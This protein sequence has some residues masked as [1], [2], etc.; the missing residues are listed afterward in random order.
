VALVGLVASALTVTALERQQDRSLDQRLN[1]R[2]KLVQRAVLAETRRYEDALR[3]LAAAI[4]AQSRLTRADFDGITSA[5]TRERLLGVSGVSLVVSA[6]RGEVA[7][8]Q[9]FWRARGST[10]L[11][12]RPVGTGAVEHRFVV[13][14]RSLDPD[15][16][17]VGRDVSESPEAVEAMDRAR[18]TGLPTASRTYVLLKDRNLPPHRRQLSF[19]I[20]VPV[21]LK[22]P[23]QPIHGWLLLGLRGRDLLAATL[24][25]VTQGLVEVALHDPA[26]EGEQPVA[27]WPV[28]DVPERA[29]LPSRTVGV[30]VGQRTWR[31]TVYATDRLVAAERGHVPLTAGLAGIAISGLLALLVLV[32]SRSRDRALVAVRRATTALQADLARR[33]AVEREL[34]QRQAELRAFAGVTAHD[35]RAPLASASVRLE[36]VAEE[37]DALSEEARD[38]LARAR[39]SLDRMGRLIGDLLAYATADQARLTREPVDLGEVVAEIV[40]ERADGDAEVEVGPLPTVRADQRMMRQLLDN[41]IGNA[42]KYRP[43]G[44]PA[45]LSVRAAPLGEGWRIEVADRGIGIPEDQRS[46]IFHAFH[47][48]RSAKGYSGTGLG[49]AICCRIVER[50]GGDMGVRDNPGGGTIFWFTLP[51]PSE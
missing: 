15:P 37:A 33:E 21:S 40:A 34:R 43:P 24:P 17:V 8:V 26:P 2:T 16:R 30:S 50:H 3:D 27:T 14:A 6:H 22:A 18:L 39:G 11:T 7:A 13:F 35:L 4:D 29:D 38:D 51:G 1:G 41:L 31:M 25:S 10:D 36:L 32:L 12:V 5:V 9:A 49:L 48:A 20:T 19:L 45:R 46:T 47:R 44:R 28:A 23:G 42:I